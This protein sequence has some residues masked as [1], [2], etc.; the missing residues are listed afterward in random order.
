MPLEV[1]VGSREPRRQLALILCATVLALTLGLAW[2]QVDSRTGLGP[3]H[4]VG[5]YPV[6]I[7]LP[8][9]FVPDPNHPNSF[10]LPQAIPGHKE[11]V[12]ERRI[13]VSYERNEPYAS[14]DA[15]LREV[16]LMDPRAVRTLHAAKL[17]PFPAAQ[18]QEVIRGRT[19]KGLEFE[20]GRLI[21][22]AALPNGHRLIVEFTT[23]GPPRPSDDAMMDDTCAAI[24]VDDPQISG[25][26]AQHL[27]QAAVKLKLADT[28]LTAGATLAG[29]PSVYIGGTEDGLPAWAVGIYRTWLV[30]GRTPQDLLV[31]F[32]QTEWLAFDQAAHIETLP[33][34]AGRTAHL[35]RHPQFGQF[36]VPTPAVCV[37]SQAPELAAVLVVR[38]SRYYAAGGVQATQEI[39]AQIELQPV[40]DWAPLADDLA[41]G[42][43]LAQTLHK[44][45][46]RPRWGREGLATVY[47]GAAFGNRFMLFVT[48][49]P[50]GGNAEFGYEG[51][52]Q[53]EDD[54]HGV[55]WRGQLTWTLGPHAQ[56]YE[57]DRRFFTAGPT[58]IRFLERRAGAN[59][60]V[61]RSL[62]VGKKAQTPQSFQPSKRFVAPPAQELLEGWVA[63]GEPTSALIDVSAALLTQT[64]S[65]RLR[66]VSHAGDPPQALSQLDY[67]PAGTLLTF[68]EQ[69]AEIVRQESDWQLIVRTEQRNRPRS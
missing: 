20:Q 24:R 9:K 40:L 26:P 57:W 30:P 3:E 25:D 69:R 4:R 54:V 52:Q 16:R 35:L 29:V 19:H 43:E 12:P 31:D 11:M 45:G 13:T 61:T 1:Y 21:R 63:R 8:R 49:D 66:H 55:Q 68:D 37:V 5:N 67:Y 56:A 47:E 15:M 39:A 14:T 50:N 28:W 10:V 58:E 33:M 59:T 6:W 62:V 32:A 41:R 23:Y 64:A 34:P 65:V 18:V 44:Q 36:D 48:R 27:A 22:F 42:V 2:Y 46:A 17:G 51:T 7:R 53:R 60:P 38:A